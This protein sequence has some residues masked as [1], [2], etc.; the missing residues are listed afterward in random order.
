VTINA[1]IKAANLARM[2]ARVLA[3]AGPESEA[4]MLKAN[5]GRAKLMAQTVR[6]ALPRGDPANG[7]LVDT[8]ASHVI[9]STGVEVAIGGPG[10]P[11]PL[12]LEVGH[13]ARDGTHVRGKPFWFP[14]KRVTKKSSLSRIVRVERAAIKKITGGGKPAGGAE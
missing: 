10:A 1:E 13:R 14:A 9:S 6:S 5:T 4:A 11:Y 8:L 2:R 12:H 7:N 3:L